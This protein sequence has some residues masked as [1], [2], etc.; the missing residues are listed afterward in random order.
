MDKLEMA[1]I[2]REII[3]EAPHGFIKFKSNDLVVLPTVFSPEH[4]T[5]QISEIVEGMVKDYLSTH[6]E[7]KVFE[8]G[9]GTGAAI[10]TVAKHEKVKAYASD[11]SPM[12]ALNTKANA[13]WWGVNCEVYEGSLF[14]SVPK[15]QFDVIFWNIPFFRE[16]PGGVEDVRFRAGFDP[17][18]KFLGQF[19]ADCQNER[20]SAEGQILLAVDHDMC[21]LSAIQALID[22]NGF[23]SEFKDGGYIKWGEMDVHLGYFFLR[24]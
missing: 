1:A 6:Q 18:Y 16:D 11:I 15:G 23:Q 19:L 8:M 24:K 5:P 13:L 17:G 14:S 4:N 7:C 3:R 9:M 22:Q 10:L 12:A 21:D 20:L 2:G